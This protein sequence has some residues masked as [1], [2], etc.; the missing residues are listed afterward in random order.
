LSYG[1]I[2]SIRETQYTGTSTLMS[3]VFIRNGLSR[4]KSPG[5]LSY[6]I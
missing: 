5:Q 3:T 6:G 1:P 4:Q 2:N